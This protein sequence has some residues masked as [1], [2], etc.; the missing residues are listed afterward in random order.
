MQRSAFGAVFGFPSSAQRRSSLNFL[1]CK[2]ECP[3]WAI[4]DRSSQF[5]EHPAAQRHHSEKG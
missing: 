3:L 5:K 2:M 1:Q 4:S